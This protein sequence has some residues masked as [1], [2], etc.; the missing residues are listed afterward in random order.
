MWI[1]V[2]PSSE[3]LHAEE[4]EDEN[5]E[6]EEEEERGDGLDRIEQRGHEVR[7]GLPVPEAKRKARLVSQSPATHFSSRE[8]CHCT[9]SVLCHFENTEE[10]DASE[11]GNPDLR[12]NLRLDQNDLHDTAQGCE[13]IEAV[14]QGYEVA[15]E[16]P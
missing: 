10:A 9:S 3:D 1:V 2:E 11:N 5:E 8:S 7:E 6:E 4:G 14:K 15:L 12:N 13:A 16:I